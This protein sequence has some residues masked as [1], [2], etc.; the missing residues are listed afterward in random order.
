MRNPNFDHIG[1]HILFFH[2][3]WF[4][5][6]SMSVHAKHLDR[7]L[8]PQSCK[9]KISGPKQH[10]SGILICRGIKLLP[11]P[12]HPAY[13]FSKK[14]TLVVFWN[15][16]QRTIKKR[17]HYP[18]VRQSRT[19]RRKR[20][21]DHPAHLHKPCMGYDQFSSP[22]LASRTLTNIVTDNESSHNCT[23]SN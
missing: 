5:E 6:F 1:P 11:S 14:S 23:R 4:H 8:G 13:G 19:M 16:T 9:N 20:G 2:F 17:V 21:T 12:L 22:S 15:E 18:H 10:R 7:N 3:S